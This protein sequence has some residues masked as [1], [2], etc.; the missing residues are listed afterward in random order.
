M[1]LLNKRVF[2]VLLY[3]VLAVP[4]WPE[5]ALVLTLEDAVSQALTHNLSIRRTRLD[6]ESKK[7]IRDTVFN[8]FYPRITASATLSRLHEAPGNVTAD[9]PCIRDRPPG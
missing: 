4:L 6:L 9:H 7:L 3:A 5:E 2:C 8:Q 1:R